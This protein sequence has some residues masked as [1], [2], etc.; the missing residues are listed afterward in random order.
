MNIVVT[1][2][3]PRCGT[4]AMM[5]LLIKNGWTTHSI[6]EQF[7]AY[8]ARE[9]NPEGFWDVSEKYLNQATPIA[10]G[11][12]ECIKLWDPHFQY[13]DW[14]TVDLMI[15]MHRPDFIKQI[16]SITQCSKAEGLNLT[17]KQ[18][19]EMFT[20]SHQNVEAVSDIV[21][22]LR[23]PMKYLRGAPKSVLHKI[24]ELI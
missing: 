12:N 3:A 23:I 2:I 22:Q 13:M 5:R 21:P 9:E 15:V 14:T 16:N 24:K 6:T 20:N 1:G 18:C 11:N 4:S 17:A 19:A 10:L 8:V 7:P